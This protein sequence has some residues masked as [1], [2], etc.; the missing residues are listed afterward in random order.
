MRT[1]TL[2]LATLSLLAA[3]GGL[4]PV[5]IVADPEPAPPIAWQEWSAET[6]SAADAT[7]RLVMVDIGIEGCTACRWMH[8]DTFGDQD[9]LRLLDEHFVA[10][11]VDADVRPDLADRYARWAWPATIFFSPEG[12][13]VLAV[14][15]NKRPHNFVP[16]LTE[17]VER[18]QA[19][20]LEP[21]PTI[22]RAAPGAPT[23]V[24]D[25]C[26]GAVRRLAELSDPTHGGWSAGSAQHVV[27]P[28]LEHALLRARTRG[29]DGLL[30]QALL[31]LDGYR[32]ITDA[33]WG[34][35]FVAS[36]EADWSAIIPE[37]RTVHQ[38][39]ALLGFSRA[40]ATTGDAQWLEAGREIDRYLS[41]QMRSREGTFY[42][43]QQ[44][45]A[46]GLP[47]EVSAVDYYGMSA[48]ERAEFGE[49]PIDTAVYTDENARV[50]RAYV[51]AFVATGDLRFADIARETAAVLT[52]DRTHETGWVMQSAEAWWI[53]DDVRLRDHVPVDRPFLSAQ[54][55]LALALLELHSATGEERWLQAAEAILL[56]A[57]DTLLDAESGAFFSTEHRV[58]DP[59]APTVPT[60]DN[61]RMARA[62]L[63]L[64]Y[65]N[66]D[67][68]LRAAA[69]TL[70]EA[71]GGG[72]LSA[73]AAGEIALAA[74]ELTL[75]LIEFSIVGDPDS[76]AA[77]ALFVAAREVAE[78]RAVIHYDQSNRYPATEVPV[79]FIC[80]DQA[81]SSPIGD[82]SEVA[83][84]AAAFAVA[85]ASA[86]CGEP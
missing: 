21:D 51:A 86:L 46:P 62:M 16:I 82:P 73:T 24:S 4:Q 11:A 48:D 30:S 15:G 76:D 47:D 56:A 5:E 58:D 37:K 38:A 45:E 75:G 80:D 49:P 63:R 1:Q 77:Q 67:P 60:A 72:R 39:E 83:A 43:T 33:E 59:I 42:S 3:C 40:Y 28:P 81:C 7:N 84:A 57:Q 78:P 34:G 68:S 85:P 31:T 32:N 25:T 23:P 14:R 18:H 70:V 35:V 66:A 53:D 27:G 19:G 55:P 12:V 79:L 36:P 69:T 29:H 65:L 54:A 26:E 2:A 44:D 20:V 52:E 10:I 13:E 74:E 6:F 8:E 64:S 71:V 17:L 41:M 9:V 61:A 50:I 22:E